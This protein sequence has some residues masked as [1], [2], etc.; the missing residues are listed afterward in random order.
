MHRLTVLLVLAGLAL[1]TSYAIA[2]PFDNPLETSLDPGKDQIWTIWPY[3][4]NAMV[5][6]AQ[7]P[8]YWPGPS[9]EDD[10][11]PVQYTAAA[12]LN[13]L[14]TGYDLEG[15]DDDKLYLTDW[16]AVNDPSG[17]VGWTS[18]DI[19]GDSERQGILYAANPYGVGGQSVNV[20]F[21]WH[22]DNWSGGLE[23]HFYDEMWYY[24]AGSINSV[25]MSLLSSNEDL[26]DLLTE[27]T[28]VAAGSD[29]YGWLRVNNY[30]KLRPNPSW[31]ILKISVSLGAP[32][33]Q[34]GPTGTFAI[35]S[36]HAATEC[37][38]PGTFALFGI[39]AVGLVIWRRR[40]TKE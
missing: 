3:Q 9:K 40:R 30:A 34:G 6:F 33:T 4:R 27:D 32:L 16:F 11:S 19:F 29:R 35:D 14:T 7:S 2:A 37:P 5:D 22:I 38:E 12:D 36:L 28:F 13:P 17:A 24:T 18:A 39:G 10:L 20:D 25:S 26:V 23:K 21:Y 31:E 8:M 15:Y 1:G